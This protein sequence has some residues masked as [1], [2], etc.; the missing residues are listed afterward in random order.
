[1]YANIV[2]HQ[3]ST[4]NPGDHIY[5]KR[6][7][8]TFG[9]LI[10]AFLGGQLSYVALVGNLP[11]VLA[12]FGLNPVVT[13][14]LILGVLSHKSS[15]SDL[16]K[17]CY[18]KLSKGELFYEH[19][20]V[21]EKRGSVI[22]VSGTLFSLSQTK[23]T[24]D[25]LTNFK[26]MTLAGVPIFKEK[27]TPQVFQ[28]SRRQSHQTETVKSACKMLGKVVHNPRDPS[29]KG[30]DII[31]RNCEHFATWCKTGVWRSAQIERILA[32]QSTKKKI[33]GSANNSLSVQPN[34]RSRKELKL[35]CRDLQKRSQEW[36][37]CPIC[38]TTVKVKK[39]IAH[40]DK[41]HAG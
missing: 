37:T 16:H 20:G 9:M 40:Y 6:E 8:N 39:L 19:H 18:Q 17:L 28:H 1:M 4:M 25:S 38:H 7:L 5:I 41:N 29:K 31:H 14:P 24:R 26:D 30:Y 2:S 34:G 13:I 23:I 3:R 12:L 21:F 27:N 36:T 35:W 15:L 10:A 32:I 33:R 11:V 22:H